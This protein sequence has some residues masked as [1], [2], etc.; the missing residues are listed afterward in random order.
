MEDL[1]IL[2]GLTLA[3]A[4]ASAF[5]GYWAGRF[6]E[7][8]NRRKCLVPQ[9]YSRTIALTAPITWEK[10]DWAFKF[11]TVA[12]VLVIFGDESVNAGDSHREQ[13]NEATPRA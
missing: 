6:V 1:A 7:L 12:E 2:L 5:T 8:L 10:L 3:L 13:G 9:P 11:G 4:A